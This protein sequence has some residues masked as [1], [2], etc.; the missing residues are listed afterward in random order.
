MIHEIKVS[1]ILTVL[2]LFIEIVLLRYFPIIVPLSN[3][4]VNNNESLKT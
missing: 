1:I 4:G 3:M 2:K